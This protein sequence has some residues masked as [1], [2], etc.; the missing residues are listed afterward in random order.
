MLLFKR[1]RVPALTY[2]SISAGANGLIIE[3]H[4]TPSKSAV[5]PLQPLNLNN[6][7]L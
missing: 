3:T 2:A 4:P 7:V 1:P 6:L 5:D